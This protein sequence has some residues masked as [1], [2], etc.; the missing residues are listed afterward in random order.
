MQ[1][2]A[3]ILYAQIG[4]YLE[5]R[6]KEIKAAVHGVIGGALNSALG[7]DFASGAVAGARTSLVVDQLDQKLKDTDLLQ[8]PMIK[9]SEF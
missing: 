8:G 3:S 4:N 5:G 2:A 1:Q 7:G 6:R 9:W